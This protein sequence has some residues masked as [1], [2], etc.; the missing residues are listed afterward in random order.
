MAELE[1]FLTSL[2]KLQ[3][4][5]YKQINE[6]QV[7][8]SGHTVGGLIQ[9]AGVIVARELQKMQQNPRPAKKKKTEPPKPVQKKKKEKKKEPT[10]KMEV[11]ELVESKPEP[12][13]V[14]KAPPPKPKIRQTEYQERDRVI[15]VFYAKNCPKEKVQIKF[16]PERLEWSITLPKTGEIVTG[17]DHLWSKIDVEKSRWDINPYKVQVYL[18]K[19]SPGQWDQVFLDEAPSHSTGPYSTNTDWEEKQRAIEEELKNDPPEGEAALMSL[20]QKIYA[21]S[22]EDTRRAMVKSYQTSGGTVLSTNWNDVKDKDYEGKDA[23]VPDG[24]VRKE[25]KDYM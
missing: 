13:E 19:Q 7:E 8:D 20:F 6:L 9:I 14:V 15:K 12:K 2:Q 25:W 21:D 3:A 17:V 10:Q 24:S 4:S 1:E 5:K 22:T 18:Y 16:F 23:V 11:E